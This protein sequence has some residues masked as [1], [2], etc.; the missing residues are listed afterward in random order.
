MII[1]SC[2]LICI[3]LI[4]S[5]VEHFFNVPIW[6]SVC[7]WGKIP[8][9]IFFFWI[10]S[11]TSCLYILAITPLSVTAFV[12]IFSH[13]FLCRSLSPICLFL[14]LFLLPWGTDLRKYYC[15]LCQKMFCL[16]SLLGVL[17]CHI[18]NSLN[19]LGFIFYMVWGNILISL[20]YMLSSFCWR[21]P[22]FSIDY[23][24]CLC[25]RLTVDVW[26]YF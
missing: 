4:I 23:S 12:N 9:L 13:S 10:L 11:Y 2:G 3:F 8:F 26:V 1:S 25:Y 20:M 15:D 18:F 16:C 22:L 6:P 24:Y 7:L 5:D 17:W 21:D 19:Y 14:F